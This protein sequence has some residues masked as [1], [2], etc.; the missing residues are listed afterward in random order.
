M[1]KNMKPISVILFLVVV[2]FVDA[3][4]YAELWNRKIKSKPIVY[5]YEMITSDFPNPVL[6]IA[7][8][9]DSTELREYYESLAKG[10]MASFDFPLQTLPTKRPLYV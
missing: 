10:E 4:V 5:G 2:L 6:A 3:W 7:D 8:L 9:K 1:M